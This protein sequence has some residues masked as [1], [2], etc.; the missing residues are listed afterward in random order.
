MTRWHDPS[1]ETPDVEVESNTILKCKACGRSCP[2]VEELISERADTSSALQ[3]PPDEPLGQMNL[4]WPESVPYERGGVQTYGSRRPSN[5]Q[6]ARPDTLPDI[7]SS[8]IYQDALRSDEFRLACLSAVSDKEAPIHV[9]LE[10]FPDNDHPE[11]ECASYAWGGEDGDSTPCRPIYI[12]LYWDVL[13]QTKNCSSL[14]RFLRPWRGTRMVWV[15]AICINQE[16]LA[17]RATQVAKMKS[18]YE[19]CFR[20]VVYLG[21]DMITCSNRFPKSRSL[22]TLQNEEHP[23][24]RNHPLRESQFD[25]KEILSRRYFSRLWVI[26]ELVASRRAVIRI[27]D[28]DYNADAGII[29]KEFLANNGVFSPAP[30]FQYLGHGSIPGKS[31]DDVLSDGARSTSAGSLRLT[32]TNYSDEPVEDRERPS[33]QNSEAEAIGGMLYVLKITAQSQAS[34]SHSAVL[35]SVPRNGMFAVPRFSQSMQQTSR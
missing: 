23:F 35:R 19:R 34:V 22:G 20:V 25:L 21:D 24:P 8:H 11:Y 6:D 13:L 31:I 32:A 5:K 2:P 16:S 9:T 10:V 26:Q 30:W 29:A 18:L 28:V 33:T 3:I 27:G 12:G 14:L 1:C 17:E 4:W 15:D 7:A